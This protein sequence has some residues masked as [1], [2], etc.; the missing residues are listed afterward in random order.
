MLEV[1]GQQAGPAPTSTYFFIINQVPKIVE[2]VEIGRLL[3]T[4]CSSKWPENR[5]CCDVAHGY[6]GNEFQAGTCTRADFS[7]I[8]LV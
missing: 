1:A 6:V 4:N 7:D 5:L 3:L 2:A 8:W